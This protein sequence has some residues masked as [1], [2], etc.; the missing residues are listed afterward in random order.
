MLLQAFEAPVL[1]K[2]KSGKKTKLT[3]SAHSAAR[4]ANDVMGL[5]HSE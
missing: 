1:V 5:I 4:Y 2:T 3:M